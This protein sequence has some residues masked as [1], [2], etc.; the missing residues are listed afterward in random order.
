MKMQTENVSNRSRWLMKRLTVM[1]AAALA[2]APTPEA[3]AVGFR[4]PNQDPEGIARGNAFAA[5]ADNPSAIYYNPAGITQL[6]GVNVRAGL[7][8]VSAGVDY[9][10]PTGV[11][12][13]VNNAFQPVPQLYAT[14]T[15]K[16]CDLSFGLGVYAPYGLAVDW[17]S[18]S[19]FRATAQEGEVK[20]VCFNPVVAWKV[21]PKL[22]LAVGP[23]VNYSEA[24]FKRGLGFIPGDYF[25]FDGN[26]TACGFNAG[27]LWRPT[28]QWSFGV[29]YRYQTE[30]E[31]D[32]TSYTKPSPPFPA[33]S[34]THGPLMYP[35]FVVAGVSYHPN[36]HWNFEVN[37]DWTDWDKVNEIVFKDT[38]FGD[39]T[40]PLNYTS[41]FMYE[42]GVT[43][44]FDNGWFMSAGYFYS[45]N[46][47]PDRYFNPIVPDTN[48]HLGSVGFGHHGEHWS[49]A[50]AYHF[51]YQAGR[52]VSGSIYPGADGKYEVLNHAFN[53]S[54]NYKF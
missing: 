16:D 20:Y 44:S 22:S 38:A 5:T 21:T 53:L 49:W 34:P 9:T 36:S 32:G 42:F 39:Q 2:A 33:S 35:Q 12:G 10:S 4:L 14:W 29:N 15:P 30:V 17:G 26:G 40:L 7:Y 47:S 51:G 8:M 23:T 52:E 11:E 48:L 27:V 13:E 18:D 25:R 37:V 31:Y 3:S 19:P 43:R 28:D 45:E 1:F 46:S 24:Y 50:A 54:L 6:E 41:S